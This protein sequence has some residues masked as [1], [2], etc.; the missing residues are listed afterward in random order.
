MLG[1]GTPPAEAC[2]LRDTGMNGSWSSAPAGVVAAPVA[3]E[4]RERRFEQQLVRHRR[5]LRG[6]H[7]LLGVVARR[8]S[9]PATT[10]RSRRTAD[11]V[12]AALAALS[13]SL[14]YELPSQFF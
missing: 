8:A 1:T 9:T 4:L 11:P 14:A 6:L 7:D 10:C 3:E 13:A 12:V 5:R 2:L